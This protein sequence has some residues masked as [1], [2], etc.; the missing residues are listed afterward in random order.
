MSDDFKVIVT[1]DTSQAEAAINKLTGKNKKV[2]VDCQVNTKPAQQMLDQ[3]GTTANKIFSTFAGMDFASLTSSKIR[4]TINDLKDLNTALVEIDK[5]SNLTK[6]ALQ[7]L[8][9]NSF[10]EASKYGALVQDYMN[11]AGEFAKAGYS[12]LDE[13]TDLAMLTQ[14]AGNVTSDMANKYL[15]ATDAAY[16]YKGAVGDLTKVIDGANNIANKNSV[17]VKDIVQ[18]ATVSASFAAQAGI[19]VEQLTAAEG[20]MAAVTKRSGSEMGRAFRSILLN[21]QQVSGEFDGEVID[22]EQLEKVEKRCH[23]L[24]VELEY[25]KD[26]I[27]T[28]RNPME[29]LKELSEVYNSLPDDSADKQGLIADIGGKYHANALSSLLGNWELYEKML[30]DYEAG[31]GSA[32]REAEKTAE[33]WQGRLN[34]LANTWTE[35]VGNFAKADVMKGGIS[36]LDGMISSFDK[37]NDAQLFIPSFLTS[38]M[39]L[40]NV[41]TGKGLTDI[42]AAPNGNGNI[43]KYNLSGTFMGYDF[44]SA[45]LWKQHF[46]DAEVALQSWNNECLNGNTNVE[47]FNNAFAK[48]NENFKNYCSTVK[49]GTASLDGYKASLAAAGV[50]VKKFSLKSVLLNAG[51]GLL[52]GAGIQ[53][54][55]SAITK[56]ID[57]FGKA[58]EKAIARGEEAL[59]KYNESAQKLQ[60]SKQ[61]LAQL[62]PE[63]GSLSRWDELSQGVNAFGENISLTADEFSE[64]QSMASQIASSFPEL[65]SGYNSLGEPILTAAGNVKALTEA[66][67][68]QQ[69]QMNQETISNAKDFIDSYNAKSYQQ[70]TDWTKEAGYSDQIELIQEMEKKLPEFIALSK[71]EPDL[72]S[73]I[74]TALVGDLA[75]KSEPDQ[76]ADALGGLSSIRTISE[77]ADELDVKITDATGQIDAQ[78]LLDNIDK[79]SEYGKTLAKE[80]DDTVQEMIPLVRSYLEESDLYGE[81]NEHTQKILSN[82]TSNIDPNFV[83]T[84]F[85]KDGKVNKD[86][87]KSWADDLTSAISDADIQS[88][89]EELFSLDTSNMSFGDYREKSEELIDYIHK[90]VPQLNKDLLKET[91]GFD[92]NMKRFQGSYNKLLQHFSKNQVDF[93]KMDDMEIA[94]EIVAEDHFSGTFEE[95]LQKI[96]ESKAAMTDL[97]A[98]PLLNEIDVAK[99]TKNAGYAYDQMVENLKT[100]KDLYDKQRTNTDD[101]R[102]I[103]A[104][105]SPTGSDDP[106]NFLE[107]YRKASRYLTEDMDGSIHF[108]DDLATKGFANMTKSVDENG[109][110]IE[111]WAI[112]ID[113]LDDA[114]QKMGISTEFLLAMFGRLDE[115]GIKN[116]FFTNEQAGIEKLSEKYGELTKEKQ[117]LARLQS[118]GQYSTKDAKALG[119]SG[120]EGNQ[121]AIDAS[122]NKI[123]TTEQEIQ[124]IK[125]NL[126]VVMEANS[127][128]VAKQVESAK[129][130]IDQLNQYRRQILASNEF[131]DDTNEVASLLESQIRELA[132]DNYIQLDA[133]LNVKETPQEAVDNAGGQ[134]VQIDIKAKT[135]TAIAEAKDALASLSGNVDGAV[136][137]DIKLDVDKDSIEDVNYRIAQVMNLIDQNDKGIVHLGSEGGE[138]LQTLLTGLIYEKNQLEQPAIMALDTSKLSGDLQTVMSTL[139]NYQQAVSQLNT[140]NDLKTAGIDVDTSQAE[141]KL[142][143]LKDEIMNLSAFQGTADILATLNVDTSSL[144]TITA[145]VASI[146]PQTMVKAGVDE[147]LVE[148]FANT[149]H[150]SEGKVTWN[151]D[152]KAVDTWAGALHTARGIVNWGNNTTGVKQ[153]FT[154]TGSVTWNNTLVPKTTKSSKG[155]EADGTAHASGTANTPKIKG[156]AFSD[157]NWGLRK[158]EDALT[159]EL[160]Q[161]LVCRDGRF[162]TVGDNGAEVVHLKQG[163]I[164]FNHEQTKAILEKGYVTGRGKLIGG[165]AR[166][167]GTAT[168]NIRRTSSSSSS[169]KKKSTSSS[170]SKS[171]SNKSSSSNNNNSSSS[172]SKDFEETIDWIEIELTRLAHT[173]DEFTNLADNYYSGYHKQNEMLNKAMEQTQK[174]IKANE[175][176]YSYYIQKANS[177]GLSGDYQ[178][179]VRNGEINIQDI[180]DENLKEKIDEYQKWYEKAQDCRDSIIDLNAELKKLGLQKIDNIIDDFESIVSVTDSIISHF[181]T[182]NKLLEAQG[183]TIDIGNLKGI[184][185]QRNNAALFLRGE[186]K[187]LRD[188]ENA[189][190]ANG[191]ITKWS[192]EWYELEAK[193]YDV[194]AALNENQANVY[195][196]RQQIREVQWKS[197]SKAIETIDALN[198]NLESTLSLINDMEMFGRDSD[199]L[200][201]NGKLKLGLVTKQLGNARQA[202]ADYEHAFSALNEELKNGNINQ[203]QYAE[204]FKELNKGRQDAI[205]NVKEYREAILDLIRDGIN[206]ET[207]AM[208][209][210]VDS[211]KD[212]LRAQKESADYARTLRDKTT[213]INKIKAQITALEGDDS[214]SAKA[215]IRNLQNQLKEAEQDL[216]D[217]QDDHAFDVLQDGYDSA[218]EKFEQIQEDELYL[219][220]S[221]LEEQNKAIQ[222]MLA[223]ARDSYQ[224][225]YDELGNLAEVYGIKLSEDLTSPWEAAQNAVKAY[226]EAVN[227][228]SENIKIDTS[229]VPKLSTGTNDTAY[230]ES[231]PSV[232]DNNVQTKSQ[233]QQQQAPA[234][235]KVSD[236]GATLRYGN[237]NE[238]VKKLQTALKQLGYYTDAI[239]GSFGNNTLNAV[240]QFQHASGITADG[241]VGKNTKNQFRVRGYATG[242]ITKDEVALFD[243]EGLGS[244][245]YITPNGVLKKFEGGTR[246]FSPDQTKRLWEL[247]QANFPAI[248]E[249][250][251][252]FK[253]PTYEVVNRNDYGTKVE[254]H[255][256]NIEGNLDESVIPQIRKVTQEEIS[257]FEQNQRRDISNNYR[258]MGGRLIR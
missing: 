255:I 73:K 179:R 112:S 95:L 178:Q 32:M 122:K 11:S 181:D 170:S 57:D 196:L 207:E 163:D 153:S 231:S 38:V 148:E 101:F 9:E 168:G 198:D 154:A 66:L 40:R 54:G 100:A 156:S 174:V 42:Y 120:T 106:V 133:D 64:Y 33:S 221:S 123:A 53:L 109:Q 175:D 18:A 117:R 111:N 24:G 184:V 36:F 94:A 48:Q 71:E 180:T 183:K 162:F 16:K 6:G 70:K 145:T 182:A 141:A 39:A 222:N 58:Q 240:K 149:E 103:A 199:L 52:V 65:V 185:E 232:P 61:L 158:A 128:E 114:A 121:T 212:D 115:A 23:S 30:S 27:A 99:E 164:V 197:F 242:G 87:I 186:M 129:L 139:Q 75:E 43:G 69:K 124:D 252:P 118:E 110:A 248:F 60:S 173:L 3:L 34:A 68:E 254:I 211:R 80:W 188:E 14:V 257:K 8:A 85:K 227:K 237:V 192:Q 132:Q 82:L 50:Q 21:L 146:T 216:Q 213:E 157:G 230:G 236:V 152:T 147:S 228:L 193:I 12:N 224:E 90:A 113:N 17:E 214:A 235:G 77:I 29:V 76:L 218:M 74:L 62:T 239:D 142:A 15:I 204:Q 59:S 46:T 177:V 26:G 105:I 208:Q 200:N 138:Q 102:T 44:T 20:T 256:D 72:S 91:T 125:N 143:G 31:E 83:D 134:D 220:N 243:E 195:E 210:L 136:L 160:G 28:L 229:A 108:L 67:A 86:T 140:L 250:V 189:L 171:S 37:L 35:F 89:L 45:N 165:S 233:Q 226:E 225:V 2:K 131:G 155:Q 5:T 202:V 245:M 7:S 10:D 98:T 79:F 205:S 246:V 151:N 119:L 126:K 223:V 93:L 247:S 19:S 127:R 258:K 219:L 144:D 130:Q 49:D 104:Y 96:R 244:E 25:M 217:T 55:L 253:V 92:D 47:D 238:D 161:E 159:G 78:A 166:S 167:G 203:E 56:F 215:Q 194:S 107:N 251:A 41:F 116:N 169:S 206:K 201:L 209:K 13:I 172:S 241:I 190:L 135:D 176:A 88:K 97:N 187:K 4:E 84:Y 51:T 1:A 81:L 22:E 191:T 150:K 137:S 249:S 63:D 234:I